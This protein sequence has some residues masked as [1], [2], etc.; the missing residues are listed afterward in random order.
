M[1]QQIKDYKFIEEIGQGEFGK[2]YLAIN[3]KNEQ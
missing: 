2:V 1:I 3:T